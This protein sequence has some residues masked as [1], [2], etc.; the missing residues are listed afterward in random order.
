MRPPESAPF[1]PN[2]RRGI[3][4]E[5]KGSDY[6]AFF[7]RRC[8]SSSA[9]LFLQ[10]SSG[11]SLDD[12]ILLGHRQV[13]KPVRLGFDILLLVRLPP[14]SPVVQGATKNRDD[15]FHDRRGDMRRAAAIATKVPV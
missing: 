11:M 6:T 10:R 12:A 7:L 13:G 5:V 8:N 14:V 4:E 1:P 3:F 9:T 2:P 15:L